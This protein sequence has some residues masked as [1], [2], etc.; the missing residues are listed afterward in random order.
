[1]SK[2]VRITVLAVVEVR[3]SDYDA[4]RGDEEELAAFAKALEGCSIP[5]TVQFITTE[6]GVTKAAIE[7]GAES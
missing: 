7:A 4:M 2:V 6:P 3:E 1:M 5:C